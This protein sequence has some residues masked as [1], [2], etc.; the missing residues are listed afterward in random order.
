M[1]DA[2]ACPLRQA[3]VVARFHAVRC[4]VPPTPTALHVAVDLIHGGADLDPAIGP[5]VGFSAPV[6]K[7]LEGAD[8]L[9]YDLGGGARI[10]GVW[11]NFFSDV[12]CAVRVLRC[13]A[14]AVCAWTRVPTG[15]YNV[16]ES[17]RAFVARCTAWCT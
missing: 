5:T 15:V 3:P 10:R 17:V 7:S 9:F 6:K 1:R 14:A 8:L 13:V 2:R 12:R 11:P 4:P 16:V